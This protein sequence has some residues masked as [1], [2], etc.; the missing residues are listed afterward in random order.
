MFEILNQIALWAL[1]YMTYRKRHKTIY[2]RK[3]KPVT[4]K[5]DYG[6]ILHVKYSDA[7]SSGVIT[8]LSFCQYILVHSSITLI[9]CAHV[10]VSEA[11]PI[12][13]SRVYASESGKRSGKLGEEKGGMVT[14]SCL[15]CV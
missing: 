2:S 9:C 1:I 3:E 12:L 10:L 15:S 8:L 14:C 7:S 5:I 13:P 4:M 11:T 6:S